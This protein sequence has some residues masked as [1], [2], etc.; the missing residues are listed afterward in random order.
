M[1]NRFRDSSFYRKI[2]PW[3]RALT[4]P[5]LLVSLGI[6][7]F[8]TNGWAYCAVGVG[9]W[10]EIGWLRNAGTVWLGLLW[11][12]GTPEKLVTFALA[13][14]ILRVLFPEDTRTL[15]VIRHKRQQ[16]TERFRRRTE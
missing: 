10:R 14:G 11:L 12:P 15:A 5:H 6:A 7:W 16:L 2:R 13:M 4:N 8:L 1:S 3:I 9:M